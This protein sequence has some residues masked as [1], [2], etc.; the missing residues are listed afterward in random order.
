[1]TRVSVAIKTWRGVISDIINDNRFFTCSVEAGMDFRS[2]IQAWV[3]ADKS[4]FADFLGEDREFCR[5]FV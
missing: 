1:M 3:D 4:V 5:F 2:T